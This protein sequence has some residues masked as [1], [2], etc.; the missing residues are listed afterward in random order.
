MPAVHGIVV[1]VI[2]VR[3]HACMCGRQLHRQAGQYSAATTCWQFLFSVC[4]W[5]THWFVV[6]SWA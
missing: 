2:I 5:A 1:I 6:L 3:P 4:A